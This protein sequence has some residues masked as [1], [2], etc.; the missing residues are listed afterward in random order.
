MLAST[1]RLFAISLRAS[2][3]EMASGSGLS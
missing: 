2:P 3:L 1:P